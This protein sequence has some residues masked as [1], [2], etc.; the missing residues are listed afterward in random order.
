MKSNHFFGGAAGGAGGGVLG[1]K[2]LSGVWCVPCISPIAG[3]LMAIIGALFC[4]CWL[5][6]GAGF[7]AGTNGCAGVWCV[8]PICSAGAGIG[9]FACGVF[10]GG[11]I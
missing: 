7:A 10:L 1:V 8:R 5:A 11:F 2:F 9:L 3:V 6:A 4:G